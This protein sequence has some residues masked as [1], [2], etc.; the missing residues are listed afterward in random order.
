LS[1]LNIGDGIVRS[2]A[3]SP[4]GAT[5]AV[6]SAHHVRLLDAR[7]GQP[8]DTLPSDTGVVDALAW[9]PDGA[10]LSAGDRKGLS[11]AA[12]PWVSPRAVRRVRGS[13]FPVLRRSDRIET[14][15]TAERPQDL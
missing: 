13:A 10:S 11:P 14:Y 8:K 12:C 6:G 9:S 5:L 7:T 1:S 15:G 4:N 3:W 2:V